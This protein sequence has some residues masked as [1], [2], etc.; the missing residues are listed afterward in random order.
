M[1]LMSCWVVARISLGAFQRA[2]LRLVM[3][4]WTLARAGR[5]LVMAKLVARGRGWGCCGGGRWSCLRTG[6]AGAA[7]K[8]QGQ[9]CYV[10]RVGGI[11][12]SFS[13]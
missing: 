1:E 10:S 7:E 6:G 11:E 8:Q 13:R 3:A 9:K 4:V 12:H 2:T 5:K